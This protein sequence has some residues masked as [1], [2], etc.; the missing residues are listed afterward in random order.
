MSLDTKKIVA[1]ISSVKDLD[2]LEKL[3]VK[4]L[5]KKSQL[6]ASLAGIGKLPREER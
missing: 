2:V 5:G 3:R 6:M 1:E 4:H